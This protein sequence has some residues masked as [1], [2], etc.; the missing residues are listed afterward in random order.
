MRCFIVCAHRRYFAGDGENEGGGY[1][2]S[3]REKCIQSFE[4]KSEMKRSRGLHL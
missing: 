3:R 2:H 4:Q 1:M